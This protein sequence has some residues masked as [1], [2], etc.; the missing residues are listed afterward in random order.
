MTEM[1]ER[2]VDSI[3][4]RR[5]ILIPLGLALAMLL[6]IVIIGTCWLQHAHITD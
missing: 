6:A 2:A 3:G 5:R 1:G 4:I